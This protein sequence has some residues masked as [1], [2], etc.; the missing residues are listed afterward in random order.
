MSS[1]G[2]IG[3]VRKNNQGRPRFLLETVAAGSFAARSTGADRRTVVRKEIVPF[4]SSVMSCTP[5]MSSSNSWRRGRFL[6]TIGGRYRK[7]GLDPI[8]LKCG[9]GRALRTWMHHT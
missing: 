4:L 9:V 3:A 2:K 5:D 6:F 8:V 7:L 1:G